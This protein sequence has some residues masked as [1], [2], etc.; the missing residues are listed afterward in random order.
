VWVSVFVLPDLD[1]QITKAEVVDKTEISEL[2]VSMQF[3]EFEGSATRRKY[4]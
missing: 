4:G 1:L 2:V 3:K